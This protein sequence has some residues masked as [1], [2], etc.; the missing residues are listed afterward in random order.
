MSTMKNSPASSPEGKSEYRV[1]GKRP[2]RHDGVD[3]VTGRALYGAD[4]QLAGLLHGR[5]LRSP[6]AHARIRSIDSR[7]AL[8]LPGV[9]AVVTGADFPTAGDKIED[10]GEGSVKLRDLCANVL[11]GEKA[12]YRGHAVAGVA[13]TSPHIA[14]QALRLFSVDYDCLRV[15]QRVEMTED[16]DGSSIAGC[17]G[18]NDDHAVAGFLLCANSS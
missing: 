3:K 16:A 17:A 8:Q 12:L 2:I 1:I 9:R 6:H 18:I 14:E 5:I 13:A 7:R 4:L 10:L 11:A 15:S